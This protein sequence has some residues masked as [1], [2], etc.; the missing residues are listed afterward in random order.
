MSDGGTNIP[1][2]TD[3]PV[4]PEQPTPPINVGP[5]TSVG[6]LAGVIN[7]TAVGSLLHVREAIQPSSTAEAILLSTMDHNTNSILA[8]MNTAY[9]IFKKVLE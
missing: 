9:N 3:V 5:Y 8:K 2:G 7:P 1:V 6:D 4:A